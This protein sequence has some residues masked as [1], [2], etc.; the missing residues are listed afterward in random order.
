MAVKKSP[1]KKLTPNEKIFINEWLIDR[2]GTRAYK[3]A[4]K[5]CGSDQT[6]AVNASKKLRKA[7]VAAYIEHRLGKL[8]KKT[9]VTAERVIREYAKL[10]FLDPTEFFDDKDN[11]L[12]ISKLPKDIAAAIGGFDQVSRTMGSG[13]DTEIEHTKKIKIID[14]KGALDSLARHLGLFEKD[15]A[16]QLAIDGLKEVKIVFVKADKNGD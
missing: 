6:A 4:F 14:K 5:R 13:V 8:A 9:E 1:L 10:A 12:P 15:N 7:N 16:G 3:V 11:L 2:N